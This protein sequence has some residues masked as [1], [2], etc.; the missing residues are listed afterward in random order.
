MKEVSIKLEYCYGI[1]DFTHTFDFSEKPTALIYSANGTMKTSLSKTLKALSKGETPKDEVFRER[2]S[3]HILVDESEKPILNEEIFVV[4]SYNEGFNSERTSALLVNKDLKKT[5]DEIHGKVDLKKEELLKEL[6]KLSGIKTVE[7]EF[8]KL[9]QSEDILFI[10]SSL[11]D[12]VLTSE[13][14]ELIMKLLSYKE[15]FNDKIISFV[16]DSNNTIDLGSY[17]E[18]YNELLK[19]SSFLNEKFNHTNAETIGKSLSAN[20]FFEA[21][22]S[23][24]LNGETSIHN[25][26]DLKALISKEKEEILDN[27]ELK[28][29]FTKIDNKLNKNKEMKGFRDLIALY[30]EI[31]EMYKEVKEFKRSFWISYLQKESINYRSLIDV[32][33]KAKE[34]IKPILKQASE[35]VTLWQEVLNEF[36]ERF[37]VPFKL[38]LENQKDVL[39]NDSAPSIKF[40]FMDKEENQVLNKPDLI[41]VLSQGEKRAFYLLN[42]IYEIKARSLDNQRCLLVMDDIADSFDYKNKYAIVEYI[43][44]INDTGNFR[45][46]ILTH[47]Y[48]FYRTINSRLDIK[49]SLRYM[50]VKNNS[51]IRLVRGNYVGNVFNAWKNNIHKSNSMMIASIPF[52]RNLAE[53]KSNSS[54][55]YKKLTCLLHYKGK[56]SLT[57]TL[58][59][60][61]LEEMYFDSW[62]YERSLPNKSKKIFDILFETANEISKIENEDINLENKVVIS[63]ATRVLIEKQI[64]RN[65]GENEQITKILGSKNSTPELIKLFE[66]EFPSE[67]NKIRVY[68]R[69]NL[70]TPENIHLNSFMFEPLLDI[71]DEY[72]NRTYKEVLAF[73]QEGV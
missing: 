26:K 10:L 58:T 69:V 2:I 41:N 52:A 30:P 61:D 18:L 22:H 71:S 21:D 56:D 68:N 28:A 51:G 43:K 49:N 39:L 73:D 48:D 57:T 38:T 40:E 67:K 14:N 36:K 17:T 70:M 31:V 55:V 53:Y 25:E 54:E 27:A 47:N 6:T 15:M 32:Y 45:M 8:K 59:I 19:G 35:E 34:E 23:I 64:V 62:G 33:R 5:Y 42:I 1:K 65:I 63:I 29:L 7:Q 46:I 11:E 60:R 16:S 12:E 20:G 44:E 37:T 3:T 72:L 4:E 66:I 13:V 9:F 24:I 50:T